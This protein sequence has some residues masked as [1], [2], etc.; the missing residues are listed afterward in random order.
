MEATRVGLGPANVHRVP[1]E[2]AINQAKAQT[3]KV[4]VSLHLIRVANRAVV[5]VESLK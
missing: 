4:Y 5:E 3:G 2:Q 1:L